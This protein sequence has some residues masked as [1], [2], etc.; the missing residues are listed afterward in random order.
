MTTFNESLNMVYQSL[1]KMTNT[2]GQNAADGK[3]MPRD[4]FGSVN[5]DGT[6]RV[7][8]RLGRFIQEGSKSLFSK[9]GITMSPQADPG[10]HWYKSIPFA[11]ETINAVSKVH[12]AM[13]SI[14]YSSS[15]GGYITRGAAFD[16]AFDT[17]NF[18]GMLPAA[19][20]TAVAVPVGVQ[21]GGVT[22][23]LELEYHRRD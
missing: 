21:G 9:L 1:A 18:A 14:N 3:Q 20:F 13:N 6:T 10:S 22:L 5:T 11:A 12:D 23:A 8:D 17:Y 16:T 7:V 4:S 19:A 15:T 2:L